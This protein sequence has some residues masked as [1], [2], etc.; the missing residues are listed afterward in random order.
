MT[1]AAVHATLTQLKRST[2][3]ASLLVRGGN[4]NRSEQ[5][6]AAELEGH[7]PND[8]RVQ[9][10]RHALRDSDEESWKLLKKW[11]QG[12]GDRV[13]VMAGPF[14]LTEKP[15]LVVLGCIVNFFRAAQY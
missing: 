7:S 4:Y 8:V 9:M 5:C 15:A 13:S 14:F 10:D 11:T 12:G 1:H 2:I 6:S 3:C